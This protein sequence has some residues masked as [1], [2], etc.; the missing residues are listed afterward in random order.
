MPLYEYEC[1]V[2]GCLFEELVR[3]NISEMACKK[4]GA[5]ADRKMSAFAPVVSGGTSNETIDMSIGREADKRW[6]VYSERQNKRRK[7][8][9]LKEVSLPKDSNGKYMPVMGL[10]NGNEKQKRTEYVGA[11]QKHREERKKRGHAQF[12]EQGSF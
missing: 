4:C 3:T 11:L 7:N 5:I 8:S 2:C 6:Q 1:K 9:D 12:N 10:G